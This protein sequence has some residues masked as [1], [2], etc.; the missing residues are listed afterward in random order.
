[1]STSTTAPRAQLV[2]PSTTRFDR[3]LRAE[4][5]K[6]FSLRSTAWTLLALVVVTVGF[7]ML[8]SW[9]VS[10]GSPQD[11]AGTDWSSLPL[12]GLGL[13]QLALAVLGAMTVSSEYTTGGIRSTLTAVPGRLR[14]LSAKGLVFLV[15]ALVIGLIVCF[16]AFE[17]AR[18]FIEQAHRPGLGDTH[19][20]RLLVG[21]ALYVAG[22]GMYGFAFGALLRQTAAAITAAVA[23]LIVL[24]PLSQL[25]PGDWGTW[26]QNHF[27]SNAGLQV[28]STVP[29]T[30]HALGVWSGYLW[31]TLEWVLLLAL[32]GFLMLRRDA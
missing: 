10:Q 20:P 29:P 25:L 17:I 30:D 22:S 8:I 27:T 2:Q 13:G 4:T 32:A 24:P 3:V 23:M 1:M 15:V 21:G 9:G 11:Q 7:G 26:I 6:M 12:T 14:L 19:V 28:M 18:L 16:A 31:F 5:I